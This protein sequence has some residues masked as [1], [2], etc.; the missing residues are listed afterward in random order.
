LRRFPAWGAV[1]LALIAGNP[2]LAADD[3]IRTSS[4]VGDVQGRQIQIYRMTPSW[5]VRSTEDHPWG[6]R[7]V[8]PVSA[9][10]LDLEGVG[11][12]LEEVFASLQSV[13]VTPGVEFLLPVRDEWVLKP[14]VEAGATVVTGDFSVTE[15]PW[16]LGFRARR[17]HQRRDWRYSLGLAASFRGTTVVDGPSTTYTT[18][19]AGFEARQATTIMVLGNPMDVGAYTIVRHNIGLEDLPALDDPIAVDWLYEAGLSFGT[20]PRP[21][22]WG[23]AL[24][25]TYLGFRW[26]A[27]L[28]AVRLSFSFP[29]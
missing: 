24:P 15:R 11:L 4:T 29:F 12:D 27:N 3:D 5:T 28:Q 13:T 19:E 6:L 8:F 16:S 20:E 2:G 7:L 10:V 25:R 21:E 14:F 22:V 1:V 9:S 23:F 18:L 26:G 17:D